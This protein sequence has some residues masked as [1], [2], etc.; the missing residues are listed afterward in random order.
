MCVCTSYIC[1]TLDVSWH[2]SSGYC[3]E[4]L[5]I[6]RTI[7]SIQDAFTRSISTDTTNQTGKNK[8]LIVLYIELHKGILKD[9]LLCFV[10]KKNS[11]D[12][13]NGMSDKKFHE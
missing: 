8:R 13:H 7:R 10:S 11:A 12:N 4:K 5:W 6:H 9:G 2:L 3:V 1:S